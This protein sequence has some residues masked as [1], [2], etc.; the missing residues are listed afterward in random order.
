MKQKLIHKSLERKVPWDRELFTFERFLHTR[1][2]FDNSKK[3]Y[4]HKIPVI[5]ITHNCQRITFS[6][7]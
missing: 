5:F 2:F 1:G 4:F 7:N 6:H 3:N